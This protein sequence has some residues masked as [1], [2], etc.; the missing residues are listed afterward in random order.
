M[1]VAEAI[2]AVQ[3]I[4][5]NLVVLPR[6]EE[7]NRLIGSYNTELERELRPAC[8][9]RPSSATQLGSILEA[10]NTLAPP[11]TV[12][13]CGL[14][15][16]TTPGVA[17]VHGGLTIHLGNLQGIKVDTERKIVSIAA[18][19]QVGNAY[20]ELVEK[21]YAVVAN[22]RSHGGIGGDALQGEPLTSH[23]S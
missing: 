9:L 22:R 21:G 15:R 2:A 7:Y 18:G 13:I 12:A 14:G 3:N 16:Q 5:R 4:S 10:I 23:I 1:T 19:E 8:F 20:R 11:S 17:N 6:T